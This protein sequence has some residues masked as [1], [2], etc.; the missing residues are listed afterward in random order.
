MNYSGKSKNELIREINRLKNQLKKPKSIKAVP[1]K[2][3]INLQTY[4]NLPLPY[5]LFDEKKI[6]Y[7]NKKAAQLLKFNKPAQLR[8]RSI[9]DIVLPEY[10]KI[11]R[12]THKKIINNKELSSLELQIKDNKGRVFFVELQ[13]RPFIYNGNNFQQAIFREVSRRKQ[14][15]HELEITKNNFELILN[16]IDEIVYYYDA[17]NKQVLY[18]SAQIEKVLGISTKAFIKNPDIVIKQCHPDD[19]K[20]IYGN[21]NRTKKTQI[22]FYRVKNFKTNKYVWIEERIFPQYNSKKEYIGSLGVS[23]DIT[24]DKENEIKIKESEA[25]FRLLAENANDIVFHYSFD[26]EPH[27]TYVSPSVTKVLGF[28]PQDFYKDPLF[29]YK[30]LHPE[31]EHLLHQSQGIAIKKTKNKTNSDH[32]AIRYITK[33]KKTIWL[34]TRFTKIK[35]GKKIIALEGI[36][37]DI[38]Q[39][40]Q[41]EIALF[42]SERTLSTLFG[43]LPGMAYRCKCDSKWTMNFVS[44]GCIDL[45]GYQPNDFINNKKIAFAD[46]VHPDDKNSGSDVLA[47]AIKKRHVFEIEYRIITKDKKIK[48]VLEKGEGIYNNDK[49]LLYIEGFITDITQR[50]ISEKEIHQERSNY[51]AVI[52]HSPNGVI[53][54]QNNKIIFANPAALRI[55]GFESF[56]EFQKTSMFDILLP[57]HRQASQDRIKRAFQGEPITPQ[58][59]KIKTAKNEILEVEI[60]CTLITF[61]GIPSLQVIISD[62]TAQKQLERETIRAQIAEETNKKLEHEIAQRK[63]TEYHL[64]Q[65]QNYLRLI[66]DSSL[67]MICAIDKQGLIT[68][69]NIAAQKTFGYKPKEIIGKPIE[70]LFANAKDKSRVYGNNIDAN[71]NFSGEA[72]NRK[73]SGETFFSLISASPL[74]NQ[75]GELIGAMSVSRDITQTKKNEEEILNQSEKLKAIFESPSHSIWTVNEKFQLT[76]F[77]KNFAKVI[78]DKFGIYPQLNKTITSLLSKEK[79]QKQSNFWNPIYNKVLTGLNTK[80]ERKD[81][82]SKGEASHRVVYLQPIFNDKNKVVEI[83]CISHDVTENKNYEKQIIEQSGKLKAIFESGNQ[84]MWSVNKN[85]EHTSFN[86]NYADSIYELYNIYPKVGE[87]IH[88]ENNESTKRYLDFWRTKYGEVFTGK[89]VEFITERVTLKGKKR[90]RQVYLHPILNENKEV[91]EVSGIAY[92]ITELRFYEQQTLKQSAKL[93]AIF[94]SGSHMIWSVDKKFNITSSNE[95]F[96]KVFNFYTS[97]TPKDVTEINTLFET[98][99]FENDKHKSEKYLNAFNGFSQHFEIKLK[100]RKN[101]VHWVEIFLEPVFDEKGK[102]YEVSGI[103]HDVT[104]RKIAEEQIRQSLKEKEVLLKEVHHRVK[105]NLQVISSILNLQ[106][107]YV[108]DNNTINLL[109]ECQNRIKSMAYI[110]ESLYQT[111]DF[112]EINFSEYLVTL[113]KNLTHSYNTFD[114]RIKSRFEVENLFLNLDTSIPCGLIVNELVSNSL[115]YAF[116][117]NKEGCIFVQLKVDKETVIL[118][119]GDNGIGLAENIDYKNTASLGLQL[120][121]TLVEQISGEINL[122]TKKGTNFTIKFKR[123]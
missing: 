30:I 46:I 23:R 95:N 71:F 91:I 88:S 13:S 81:Y 10:H 82:N 92:D 121:V 56:E 86:K 72:V 3:K 116:P 109:K 18:I 7:F 17:L 87:A 11:L 98:I 49:E 62:L 48:W 64:Q 66:I 42:E 24:K 29:G 104:Q 85:I 44:N 75:Q 105:N 103:A 1:A 83:S 110:H 27:Y 5:I 106:S 114:N 14:I 67:D 120:V 76:S 45:T 112:S 59:Y 58:Q 123:K 50:K 9:F 37:R 63:Q 40:K 12:D 33:N 80:I 107:S 52:D 16:N 113:V 119:I 36:S 68:E 77:N 15:I 102:V 57:E 41:N 60:N 78:Y 43:N 35:K 32:L 51:K 122:D 97:Q 6:I 90:F 69:F 118:S 93:K 111:K 53:I 61:N 34:E 84:M 115:K 39:Q 94:D 65:T 101:N 79:A 2:S 31:D 22:F 73:K 21:T 70:V 100:G 47:G 25:K 96:N 54:H 108:N 117:E 55:S 28:S 8:P 38:S 74:K 89:S 4:D 99:V 19:L 26:P 20:N